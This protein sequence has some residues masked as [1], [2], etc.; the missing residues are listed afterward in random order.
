MFAFIIKSLE[1]VPKPIPGEGDAMN[2]KDIAK[3]A[4]VGV[5]TVSRVLNDHKDVSQETREKVLAII[6]AEGY[7][8]NDNAR[9]LKRIS[10]NNIGVMIRGQ[11]NPFFSRMLEVIEEE[12]TRND[13]SMILHYNHKIGN[14]IEAA[15]SLITEKKLQG[16]ICL[17]GD[18]DGIEN[19]HIFELDV[20]IVLLSSTIKESGQKNMFS[21]VVIDNMEASRYAVNRLC[22][23]GHSKIGLITTSDQD[24]DIGSRRSQGYKRALE[25]N[26]ITFDWKYVE[27]ADYDFKSGY[28]A[29]MRLLRKELGISALFITSDVMAIGASKAILD[30]GF[31][32]PGDISVIGFDGLDYTEFF[33][34]SLSTVVQPIEKMGKI[35]AKMIFQLLNGQIENKHVILDTE[36]VLRESCKYY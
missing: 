1:T 34:P 32:I 12:I 19:S 18:F 22:K 6:E 11:F 4:G 16:L 17:G 36:L 26:E 2:I 28:D 30:Y 15:S 13:H 29:A 25:D 3:L 24:V 21:S 8:P 20:P 27:M 7:V 23:M 35:G 5:S 10:T 33:S 31:K 14:D 9:N